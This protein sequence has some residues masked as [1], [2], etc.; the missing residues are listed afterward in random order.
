[1]AAGVGWT[2][3]GEVPA[4]RL[5]ARTAGFAASMGVLVGIPIG[6]GTPYMITVTEL[7]WGLKTCFFFAGISAPFVLG[8]WFIIPETARRSPAELDELF[9]NK[10]KPWR[11]RKTI[12][13]VEQ[14]R[15]AVAETNNG[16]MSN[17]HP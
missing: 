5:K 9:S 14:A 6:Y 1:M 17:A 3:V 12:T 8:T 11:F 15:A 16:V 2:M 7:N 4:A 10:V 13:E